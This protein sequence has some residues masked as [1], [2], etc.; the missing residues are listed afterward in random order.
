[1]GNADG[2]TFQDHQASQAKAG[3]VAT[4]NFGADELKYSVADKT[5]STTFKTPYT[6]LSRDHGFLVERNTWLMNVGLL[7]IALGVLVTGIKFAD[8]HAAVP[9]I[10]LWLGLGCAGWAWFRT[11]R[12]LKIPSENGTLLIIEDDQKAAILAELDGRRLDQLRRWHDFIDAN[13][14]PAR[15]RGRFNWLHEEGALDEDQLGERL[16][17][18]DRLVAPPVQAADVSVPGERASGSFLN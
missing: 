5:S 4:F 14:D 10:W 2:T 1:M 12:Y 8:T 16:G 6:E 3:T 13:E 11:I 18:L 17:R 7:W 15:Q 9:S